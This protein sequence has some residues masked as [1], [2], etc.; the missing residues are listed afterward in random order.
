MGKQAI[1]TYVTN[2]NQR[3]DTMSNVMAYPQRP[4][5]APRTSKHT[6][7]DSLHH[8]A[9]AMVAIATYTGYNQEDSVIGGLSPAQ[10]GAYN[11]SWYRTY[12]SNL[13]KLTS[14]DATESFEVPPERTIRRKVGTGGRDRY[15]AIQTHYGKAKGRK[16]ELPKIGA[17]VEGNDIIIPK[18]KK[19]TS[20]K[21]GGDD[22]GADTLYTD[23]SVTVKPSEGGVIDMVIPN[24]YIT[25]NENEDANQFIKARICEMRQPEIGDKFA[26]RH[27]QKGTVGIQLNSADIM[28]NGSGTMPD[29]IMNPHAI[30]SRMTHGQLLES[31]SSKEGILTGK[32]HDATPF[33][34][35]DMDKVKDDL[36]LTGYDHCGDEIMYNGFTGEPMESPI[37]FWPT[38][39]QRLKHMVADKMHARALGPIQALTKQPAE[40]RSKMGGLRLGEMER[41]CLIAHSCAWFLKEKTV[42][43][44]DIF[45]VFLSEQKRTVI[46]A[47]PKLGI[48]QCG[49]EEIYGK[50]DI[51]TLHM[52]Y[53]MN[54]FRN[55]LR[56]ML[57]DMQLIVN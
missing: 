48:F 1:G 21:R 36:E 7:L 32:F 53:A 31:V 34:D 28:V 11:T 49:T 33:T 10:R 55:E 56:T 26:S 15:H 5:V 16:P 25:N 52:P 23:M 45:E 37:T 6:R 12:S 30:P 46:A 2:H 17:F 50:D 13:Q 14:N 43:S 9:N 51:A 54:L 3:M 19:V 47:N 40:G 29:L 22:D 57:V 18:S 44:S 41:D 35:F 42:E 38:Y 4:L 20:K 8:G 27:A 24:E 39:Y